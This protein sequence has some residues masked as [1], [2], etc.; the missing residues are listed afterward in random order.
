MNRQ[1]RKGFKSFPMFLKLNTTLYMKY[2][3]FLY[4]KIFLH[5]KKRNDERKKQHRN[6]VRQ[7]T[8]V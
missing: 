1:K 6:E 5:T 4:Y 3:P 8:K 2:F 7:N